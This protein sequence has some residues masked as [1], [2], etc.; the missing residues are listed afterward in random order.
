VLLAAAGWDDEAIRCLQEALVEYG[1]LAAK[2]G[3]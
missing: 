2:R 3:A 1:R